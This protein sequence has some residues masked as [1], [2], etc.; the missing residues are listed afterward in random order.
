MIYEVKMDS[1]DPMLSQQLSMMTGSTMTMFF[2]ENNFRQDMDMN[3]MKSS[4]VYNEKRGEG[5]G[6][7]DYDGVFGVVVVVPVV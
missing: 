2:K 5:I 3:M 6:N 1:D 7:C 4:T